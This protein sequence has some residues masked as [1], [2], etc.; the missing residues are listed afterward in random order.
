MTA[1]VLVGPMIVCTLIL[2]MVAWVSV[3]IAARKA[4]LSLKLDHDV[5]LVLYRLGR[6]I[7]YFHVIMFVPYVLVTLLLVY[8]AIEKMH[9]VFVKILVG[10]L[11][12]AILYGT[13]KVV[14]GLT[15]YSAIKQIRKMG[16]GR[17]LYALRQGTQAFLTAFIY[18]LWVGSSLIVNQHWQDE[19][20]ALVS[21]YF[22]ITFALIFL[23]GSWVTRLVLRTIPLS[24]D[25]IPEGWLSLE[26]RSGLKNVRFYLWKTKKNRIANAMAMGIFKKRVFIS[27]YLLEHI[28][29]PER[30]AV[31]AHELGHLQKRH[32]L[33]MFALVELWFPLVRI[34][35]AVLTRL[36]VGNGSSFITVL[37]IMFAY[38]G[39]FFHW[40]SRRFEYQADAHSL[41]MMG[42]GVAMVNALRKL[43]DLTLS[44]PVIP[45]FDELWM[46]HPST[47]H[48]IQKLKNESKKTLP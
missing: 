27:D 18:G 42:Q 48:R 36:Q 6:F 43:S 33:Q 12:E 8:G 28:T 21:L 47:Q 3:L 45:K 16:Q 4:K 39:L 19:H 40:L 22:M 32:L 26:Q 29:E 10:V 5:R 2:L 14:Y 44:L 15:T 17:L 31:I 20:P 38:Q 35:Q 30:E 41:A 25:E 37:V 9:P 11:A 1:S 23:I 34:L 7:R 24:R 46:T 13:I